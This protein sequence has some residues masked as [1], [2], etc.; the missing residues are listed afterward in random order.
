MS[1]DCPFRMVPGL[2][3]S[4]PVEAR[5]PDEGEAAAA[6]PQTSLKASAANDTYSGVPRSAIRALFRLESVSDTVWPSPPRTD[7]PESSTPPPLSDELCRR[8]PAARVSDASILSLN[9][10]ET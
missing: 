9:V 6:F 5:M 1:S 2:I 4:A 7:S 3:Q 10:S 8:T